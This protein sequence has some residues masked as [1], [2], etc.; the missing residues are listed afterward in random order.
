MTRRQSA[1]GVVLSALTIT[2]RDAAAIWAPGTA[3]TKRLAVPS[4]GSPSPTAL[5]A[6]QRA[7]PDT[8]ISRYAL[9]FRGVAAPYEGYAAFRPPHFSPSPRQCCVSVGNYRALRRSDIKIFQE[10]MAKVIPHRYILTASL[11][12][13]L[14]V[15]HAARRPQHT[16]ASQHDIGLRCRD[17]GWK[18]MMDGPIIERV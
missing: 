7:L 3:S 16:H 8:D 2:R 18:L 4:S 15:M 9:E 11:C 10:L 6:S 12:R 14:A 1:A 13:L 17:D 5:M